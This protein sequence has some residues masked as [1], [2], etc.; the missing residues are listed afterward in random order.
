MIA[1]CMHI[2]LGRHTYRQLGTY[3]KLHIG[4]HSTGPGHI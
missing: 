4:L 2:V 3:H 1:L